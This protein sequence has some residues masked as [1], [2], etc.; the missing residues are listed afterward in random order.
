MQ[1]EVLVEPFAVRRWNSHKLNDFHQTASVWLNFILATK[2]KGEARVLLVLSKHPI[3]M[4]FEWN[5]FIFLV[6]IELQEPFVFKY[7]I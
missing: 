1:H 6:L 2:Q 5:I 7:N 3:P 4:F